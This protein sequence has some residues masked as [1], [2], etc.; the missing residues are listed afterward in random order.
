MSRRKHSSENVEGTTG[1]AGQD[2]GTEDIEVNNRLIAK[3]EERGYGR[4]NRGL[5]GRTPTRDNKIRWCQLSIL[6]S[7][8][9]SSSQDVEVWHRHM[10]MGCLWVV[11]KVSP[12]CLQVVSKLSPKCL[13]IILE[14]CTTT[15]AFPNLPL[16]RLVSNWGVLKHPN[17]WHNPDQFD[18]ARI[19]WLLRH[20]YE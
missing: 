13:Q 2:S 1:C 3:D 11:S 9:T 4:L 6:L 14:L 8:W 7:S 10:W 12:R 5:S 18:Q 16:C 17:R 15:V 20:Q 19:K